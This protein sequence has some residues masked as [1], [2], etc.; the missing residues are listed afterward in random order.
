MITATAIAVD[1]NGNVYVTGHC[2]YGGSSGYDYATLKYDPERKS[3]L[4]EPLQWAGKANH[5]DDF[6]TAIAVDGNGNVYVTG[7]SY[8]GSSSP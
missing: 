3:A 2:S 4:G 7:Y 6:A 1:G 5:G 8:G